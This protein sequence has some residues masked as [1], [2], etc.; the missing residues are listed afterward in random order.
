MGNMTGHAASTCIAKVHVGIFAGAACWAKR[1][2]INDQTC[3]M[4][5]R[6]GERA[7]QINNAIWWAKNVPRGLAH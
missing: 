4:G 5:D 7:G 3:S 1:S 6:S 2:P